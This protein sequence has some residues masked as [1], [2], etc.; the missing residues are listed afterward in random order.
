MEGNF[1]HTYVK[2]LVKT[3]SANLTLLFSKDFSA[4]LVKERT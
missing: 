4:R 1:L 3:K 2:Y